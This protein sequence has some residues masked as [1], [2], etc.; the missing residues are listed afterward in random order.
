MRVSVRVALASLATAT[1]L[2]AAVRP[3]A[4]QHSTPPTRPA[5]SAKAAES[6][7]SLLSIDGTVYDSVTAQPLAGATVQ[8]ALAGVN[9]R[10][11]VATSGVD[12]AFHIDSVPRGV[13]VAAFV[14]PS[15]DVIGIESPVVAVRVE[16]GMGP[17]ELSVPSGHRLFPALCPSATPRDSMAALVGRVHDADADI[18]LNAKVV[19]TWNELQLG[20][21]KMQQVRRRVP[22]QTRPD[23]GFLVCGLPANSPLVVGVEAPGRRSGLIEV[24]LPLDGVLRR[25]FAL[26]D[27]TAAVVVTLPAPASASASGQG[28]ER[29]LRGSAR[30]TGTVRT[31]AGQPVPGARVTVEGTGVVS[32]TADDGS[33]VLNSLPA[34]TYS[35]V[36]RAVGYEPRGAAVDLSSRRTTVAAIVLDAHVQ[37]LADVK[38]TGKRSRRDLNMEAFDRRRAQG[39]GRYVTQEDIESRHPLNVSDA[40]STTPGVHLSPRGGLSG[41][42]IR[43]R[44]NC[45]P[46]VAIDGMA[47]SGAADDID[48]MVR[49]GD[50]AG[51]EVYS[52]PASAPAEYGYSACGIVLIWTKR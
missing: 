9:G 48:D 41:Y 13:Y 44:A 36:A 39:F 50:V 18:G 27:T 11:W 42:A 33:F 29:V 2:A 24:T 40:L 17:V 25:D 31:K 37:M 21:G 12:G 14:H 5:A 20:V 19:V 10:L 34:G 38:V 22:A 30:L 3:A 47:I 6:P 52:D 35:L 32:T 1:A 49:P 46:L 8:V 43:G 7:D 15:L 51:I 16:P 4:A 45:T 26:A 23:G 28:G